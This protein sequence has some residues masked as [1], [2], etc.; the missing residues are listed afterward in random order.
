VQ[1]HTEEPETNERQ[2]TNDDSAK[3]WS[4]CPRIHLPTPRHSD[5]EEDTSSDKEED[6]DE[7]EL[8]ERLPLCL[9]VDV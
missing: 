4:A 9:A 3:D 6:T 8:L 5:E 7:V 2:D 1:R